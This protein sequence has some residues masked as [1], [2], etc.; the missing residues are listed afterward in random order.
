MA[1]PPSRG[2]GATSLLETVIALFLLAAAMMASFQLFHR[3]T[4]WQGE[5]EL[6]ATALA[7]AQAKIAELQAAA[8]DLAAFQGKLSTFVG[9]TPAMDHSSFKITVAVDD[10][11]TGDRQ[12]YSPSRAYE[13]T[14]QGTPP[15]QPAPLTDVFAGAVTD[16]RKMMGKSFLVADVTV[17]GPGRMQPVTLTTLLREPPRRLDR[18]EVASPSSLSLTYQQGAT[19]TAQAIDVDNSPIDD[20]VFKWTFTPVSSY[21]TVYQSRSGSLGALVYV[22]YNHL[23][24][25]FQPPPGQ[26]KLT[27]SARVENRHK[28]G[29]SPVIE[30]VP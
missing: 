3:A 24:Q 17:T 29:D 22:S 19:S 14:Y 26:C 1:R 4:A 25:P 9:T 5:V 30:L 7:L 10:L 12:I 28:T 23:D 2:A 16:D 8:A 13:Q 20:V 21:G 6:R 18:I 15:A 27:A 11:S